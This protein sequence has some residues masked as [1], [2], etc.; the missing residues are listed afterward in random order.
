[1]LLQATVRLVIAPLARLLYRPVVEGRENVP[2]R[3]PVILAAN[4]LSFIDSVV[5]PLVAPR[6]V[7]FLAKAEYFRRPGLKGRLTR[8]CLTGIDAIPVQRGGH[9]EARAS[10]Q[11]AL[12]VLA[13]GRAFGLHPEG[14]RS[15][16]GRIYRGRTG[17][18][19]L[20]LASG[21]PVVPVAVLGTDRIQPIGARL[22][23][24]GKVTVRFGTPLRFTQPTGSLGQAR[25]AVTD[26]IMA[27]IRDLSGQ[28]PADGYNDLTTAG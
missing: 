7:A 25:R 19:W 22:P 15:R 13:E 18:A 17:V 10:L 3:G 26:E 6:P 1:M 4:H 5:I 12:D 11:L 23:R 16:D 27:A 20:A 8:T 2:R 24:L 21:A 28:E 14:S 9:R